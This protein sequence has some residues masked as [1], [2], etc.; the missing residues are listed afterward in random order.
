[1][2]Q[3]PGNVRIRIYFVNRIF[4]Q[5]GA[6]YS[7]NELLI[8]YPEAD[9]DYTSTSLVQVLR[10]ETTHALVEQ[11]LGSDVHKGGLLGEG[12]AVW[13]AGGHYQT[14]SVAP[15]AATLV[16]ENSEL[17]IPLTRLRDDFY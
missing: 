11:M 13:A 8:S 4:W 1:K 2:L 5:G 3:G 10:H 6:S 14:E 12:V 17:Y 15:L 7:H 16:A 9:R